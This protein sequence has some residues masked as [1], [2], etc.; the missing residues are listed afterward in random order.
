VAQLDDT[1]QELV[2]TEDERAGLQSEYTQF[3]QTAAAE[4]RSLE[5]QLDQT[6]STVVDLEATR[7]GLNGQISEATVTAER[8][9]ADVSE[10]GEQLIAALD[11]LEQL[12]AAL[13]QAQAGRSA[14]A[15]ELAAVR[16]EN[17]EGETTTQ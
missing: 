16:R 6:R 2:K 10:L 13:A 3:R 7:D 17:G 8:C 5:N 11:H 4:K 12:E 15:A 1:Q 9:V 14:L